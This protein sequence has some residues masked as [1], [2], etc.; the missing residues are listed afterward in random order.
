M[1]ATLEKMAR[2]AGLTIGRECLCSA[3][4]LARFA[5][6]VLAQAPLTDSEALALR[7]EWFGH[8]D[9]AHLSFAEAVRETMPKQLDAAEAR[10][11]ALALEDAAQ[12]VSANAEACRD[13]SVVRAVLESNAAAIRALELAPHPPGAPAVPAD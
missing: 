11:R 9:T 5:A 4:A 1:T 7:R 2:E 8:R 13:G 6:L 10:G 12:L 3:E